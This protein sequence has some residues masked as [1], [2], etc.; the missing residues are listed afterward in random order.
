MSKTASLKTAEI[1]R[2]WYLVDASLQPVGRIS[3]LVARLLLGKSKS[4]YTSHI[5]NGDFVVVINADKYHVTGKK[6]DDKLYQH[7]TGF[8]G[9][10]RTKT[11]RELADQDPCQVLIKSVGGMLPKN[12]LYKARMERLKVF[13]GSE[14]PHTA[15]QPI[16]IKEL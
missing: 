11:L 14:H 10:L 8:P 5:D 6:L 12:K 3:T 7:H 2:K 1:T 15:Q 13:A 16:E 4:T 9:A